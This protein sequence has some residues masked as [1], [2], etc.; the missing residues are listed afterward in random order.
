MRN[1]A[2][3][4]AAFLAIAIALVAWRLAGSSGEVTDIPMVTVQQGPLSMTLEETGELKAK[5]SATITAPNDKLITFLAPEGS[6]VKEGDLL[7]QLESAKYEIGVQESRSSLD[8]AEAQQS[9]AQADL[10]AQLYKE[11]AAK[12]QYE[13]LLELQKKGFAMASE[14]EE[15]RL[16]Y[17]ELQSKTG[18]FRAAVK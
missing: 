2:F 4:T 6:W 3:S 7:V 15:A 18:A 14:V 9:R 13:A 10:Q 11:E 8:V 17:L 12:K 1:K 16:A 5:R